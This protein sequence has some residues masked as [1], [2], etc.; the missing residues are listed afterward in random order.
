MPEQIFRCT[1]RYPSGKTK[2]VEVKLVNF[3]C[4]P[5]DPEDMARALRTINKLTPSNFQ[6]LEE[7]FELIH[8]NP[9]EKLNIE[10]MEQLTARPGK[11]STETVKTNPPI[12]QPTQ[13]EDEPPT[14]SKAIDPK[15]VVEGD[16][17]MGGGSSP[18]L[19]TLDQSTNKAATP[20][21]GRRP[22]GNSNR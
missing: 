8:D 15:D 10:N 19:G 9:A 21:S 16:A 20:Q 3:R 1:G 13:D 7:G 6:I 18:G 5:E 14:V 17:T 4:D 2:T 12:R 22:T 11:M